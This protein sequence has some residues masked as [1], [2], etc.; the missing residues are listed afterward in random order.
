MVLFGQPTT[1]G[2]QTVSKII[3]PTNAQS[4]ITSPYGIPVVAIMRT[5]VA[6]SV[7]YDTNSYVIQLNRMRV[8]PGL[9]RAVTWAQMKTLTTNWTQWLAPD[10]VCESASA[11]VSNFVQTSL[12]NN[13][14]SAMTPYDTARTLHRAVMRALSYTLTPPSGDA[15][16]VLG[17]GLAECSGYS[18]L[19]TAC[20]RNVGIPSRVISGNWQGSGYQGH[21]RVEF[22]LPG[23]EW[24]VADPTEGNGVDPTGT[25]AYFFGFI[26]DADLFVSA[27]VGDDHVL[28]NNY[29][30]PFNGFYFAFNG[31]GPTWWWNSGGVTYN[32]YT[33][34]NDFQPNGVLSMTNSAK[35]TFQFNLTDVPDEGSVVVQTSTNLIT[36]S[37]VLTNSAAGNAINYSFPNTNGVRRFYRASV[38][39]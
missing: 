15:I 34:F 39:P 3:M 23:T 38:V 2:A 33:D 8:N 21:V 31:T 5:N 27:D 35:G 1:H 24:L 30:Q 22:H 12:P 18:A 37:P 17:S 36:W 11:T 16:G 4:V 28:P 20:L 6:A 13:Y 26:P 29:P 14:K 9:L 25:F 10:P 7:F 32:S 19:L